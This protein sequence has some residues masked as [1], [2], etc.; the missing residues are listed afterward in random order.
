MNSYYVGKTIGTVIGAI[1][2]PILLYKI[3]FR[4]LS[5]KRLRLTPRATSKYASVLPQLMAIVLWLQ[6]FS[7][8]PSEPGYFIGNTIGVIVVSLYLSRQRSLAPP[9]DT[10]P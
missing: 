7:S 4:I 5:A 1:L 8:A 9:E 6:S 3:I 10:T 2:F